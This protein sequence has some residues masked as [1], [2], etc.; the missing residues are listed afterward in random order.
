MK[1]QNDKL[2]FSA[3][4]ERIKQIMRNI[5]IFEGRRNKKDN[6]YRNEIILEI[7]D[8]ISERDVEIKHHIEAKDREALEAEICDWLMSE[9]I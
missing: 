3:I 2:E 8:F 7:A 6:G 1:K 4:A 5:E 9:H